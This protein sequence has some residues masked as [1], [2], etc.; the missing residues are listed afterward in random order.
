MNS[1]DKK[2]S[3]IK[4]LYNKDER[5]ALATLRELYKQTNQINEQSEYASAVLSGFAAQVLSTEDQELFER[6]RRSLD[7]RL[8]ERYDRIEGT[9]FA[10]LYSE[11]IREEIRHQKIL[12]DRVINTGYP[13]LDSILRSVSQRLTEDITTAGFEGLLGLFLDGG[14]KIVLPPLAPFIWP[15]N[16][17]I[18]WLVKVGI[19][20]RRDFQQNT[21]ANTVYKYYQEKP[22]TV[23]FSN[24]DSQTL[25]DFSGHLP[26]RYEISVKELLTPSSHTDFSFPDY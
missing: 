11:L 22:D 26:E 18:P 14:L 9:V 17:M 24:L 25:K 13:L 10:R 23:I 3:L 6:H 15:W 16:H 8:L 12:G 2:N 21:V 19:D 7:E 4:A 1:D 5:K 20:V